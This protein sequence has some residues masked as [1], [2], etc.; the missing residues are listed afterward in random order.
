VRLAIGIVVGLA[1]KPDRCR[2]RR[3]L[4]GSAGY[5]N[6]PLFRTMMKVMGVHKIAD[7]YLKAL[8]KK[9]GDTVTPEHVD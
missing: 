9:L 4:R 1:G 6:N 2:G 3:H 5:V 8:G 7:G